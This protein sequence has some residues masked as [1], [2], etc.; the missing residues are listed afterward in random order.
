M[1]PIRGLPGLRTNVSL[2]G[3][4]RLFGRTVRHNLSGTDGVPAL[5]VRFV[6]LAEHPRRSHESDTRDALWPPATIRATP[7]RST[8]EAPSAGAE[9][10]REPGG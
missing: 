6:Q 10:A 3:E 9:R 2:P 8:D 4:S 5:A 1:T 7:S